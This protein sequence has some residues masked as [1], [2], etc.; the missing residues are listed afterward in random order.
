[1][2]YDFAGGPAGSLTDDTVICFTTE[3]KNVAGKFLKEIDVAAGGGLTRLVESGEFSGKEGEIA[4]FVSPAEFATGRL[5][6]LGLGSPKKVAADSFRRAMGL[7]SRY[8]GLTKAQTA[9][10]HFGEF[11]DRDYFQAAAEGLLLG[12]FRLLDYKTGEAAENDNRLT[13]VTFALPDKK[14]LRALQ[15]AVERGQIIAEG[16]LL[17]R[18]LASTPANDLTPRKYAG[19]AQQL[20]KKFGFKCKILDEKAIAAEKMGA[21]LGVAQG[22]VEPPRFLILEYD[23]G[24]AGQKPVALVGK[25]VT[26]DSGGI[27]LKPSLNMHEMKQDMAGSAA[28][29]STVVTA[30]RLGLKLNIVGLIPATENM[31]SGKATKP[32][33]IHVSRKG[34]TIEIINTDA[35]GRLI[36]ADALDYANEFDPQA[37]IDVATLTGAT[38]YILGYAGA[39]I[40]GNNNKLLE[41]IEAGAEATSE[42]VWTL[43]I[44]NDHRDQM[45]SNI[46]DLVNSGGRA[47]G[48]IAAGAF[49]E[50]FIGDWPWAHIDIAAV[51]LEPSGKAYVPKGASGFGV[52]L[53]TEV[54]SNW[55]RL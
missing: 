55:K 27:S 8:K 5:L 7:V 47:A 45:K 1:M 18:R 19:K 50:N 24:K 20:A 2:K 39:P 38:L 3:I 10:V 51:D 14:R 12:S 33:D 30:A 15:G 53:L 29:L 26:F 31:P 4:S 42:R 44:W 16:Q 34:K 22:S 28:V 37:V 25:G 40:L 13:S 9:A 46:A 21:L 52:R 17:A 35:E 36:L 41:R 32:G 54:L 23:G 49:L 6:L 48:T 11:T 43:P